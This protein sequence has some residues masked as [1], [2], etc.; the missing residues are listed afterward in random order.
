VAVASRLIALQR[1][2]MIPTFPAM[3]PFVGSIRSSD[4]VWGCRPWPV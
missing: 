3:Y 1:Q 4:G 2:Q